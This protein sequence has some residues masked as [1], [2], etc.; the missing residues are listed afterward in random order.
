LQTRSH[1][2]RSTYWAT[3]CTTGAWTPN[4]R[5]CNEHTTPCPRA[6]P[7]LSTRH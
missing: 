7:R 3:S 6:A 2:P 5:C 1:Q 4:A